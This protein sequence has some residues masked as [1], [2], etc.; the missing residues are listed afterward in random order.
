MFTLSFFFRHI[1]SLLPVR[2]NAIDA[3]HFFRESPINVPSHQYMGSGWFK[4]VEA[5]VKNP[6]QEESVLDY[7]KQ[8]LSLNCI[9]RESSLLYGGGCY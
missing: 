5:L 3:L 9:E 4:I 1:F 2:E 6:R 8:T 7:L